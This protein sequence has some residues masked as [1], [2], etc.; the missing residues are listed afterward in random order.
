MPLLLFLPL[1]APSVPLSLVI[2]E[3]WIRGRGQL[4]ERHL[5]LS[6]LAYSLK[7][8]TPESFTVVFFTTKVSTLIS[9]EG[10]EA[11]S[12]SV[13]DKILTSDN[14]FSSL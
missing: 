8:D 14:L 3:L 1:S 10:D 4:G 13:N 9:V 6:F 12:R 7:I 11:L 2:R 5:I